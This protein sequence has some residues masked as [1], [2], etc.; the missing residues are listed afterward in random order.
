M[1][2]FDEVRCRY[3]LPAEIPPWVDWFQTKDLSCDMSQFEITEDGRLVQTGAFFGETEDWS[4]YHG[5]VYFY[6]S[7][8]SISTAQGQVYTRDGTGDNY[9]SL[10]FCVRFTDGKVSRMT[11]VKRE[12][13]P[14]PPASAYRA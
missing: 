10:E 11:L 9:I 13:Y 6:T 7:N 4:D 8:W 2:M 3:P 14:A 5:D 1:G 12:E